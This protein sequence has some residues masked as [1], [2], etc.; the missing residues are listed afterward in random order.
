MFAPA[1]AVH[2][3]SKRAPLSSTQRG[4]FTQ[5]AQCRF[6]TAFPSN[7]L[8]R[9]HPVGQITS[10][11][12][13]RY[14]GNFPSSFRRRAPPQPGQ[15]KATGGFS[16]NFAVTR[17][18]DAD[19]K[20]GPVHVLDLGDLIDGMECRRRAGVARERRPA[21]RV[22]LDMKRNKRGNPRTFRQVGIRS[23]TASTPPVDG[24]NGNYQ[25]WQGRRS[26]NAQ[27]NSKVPRPQ[28]RQ[29][30]LPKLD[31]PDEALRDRAQGANGADVRIEDAPLAIRPPCDPART[32]QR[33][34]K[35]P[36]SW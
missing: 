13:H 22:S 27:R 7:K 5:R 36:F 14:R 15:P 6:K 21:A 26:I 34:G 10:P 28:T 18:R 24:P 11:M 12:W 1:D 31:R 17:F 9:R 16:M 32:H 30:W 8:R 20:R 33:P 35:S 4:A 23:P 29:H 3:I 2:S 19:E 25:H